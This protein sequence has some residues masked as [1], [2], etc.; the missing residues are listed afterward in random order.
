MTM[1]HAAN[2]ETAGDLAGF[3]QGWGYVLASTLPFVAGAIKDHFASLTQAWY[4]MMLGV[5]VMGAVS[6]GFSRKSYA[7]FDARISLQD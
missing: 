7:A 3:V 1:D 5:V 2:P 4:L 6:L